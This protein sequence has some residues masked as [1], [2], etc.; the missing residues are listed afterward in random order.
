MTKLFEIISRPKV[1]IGFFILSTIIS[2]CFPYAEAVV[3]GALLDLSMNG[4]SALTRLNEMSQTQK[5]KHIWA[6]LVLDIAYPLTLSGFMAGITLHY[7]NR[8]PQSLHKIMLAPA[9]IALIMDL[10]ENA[11]QVLALSGHAGLL[12]LKTILTP[13]KFSMFALAALIAI[14]L[15]FSALITW[16][17]ARKKQH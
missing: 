4:E 12:S 16:M 7:R 8:L 2:Y 10:C 6:T 14:F 13:L 9:L 5:N 11:V 3:G 1:F 17:R 15:L